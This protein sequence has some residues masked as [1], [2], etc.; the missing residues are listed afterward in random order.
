MTPPRGHP[1]HP[2]SILL[3]AAACIAACGAR[4][5][6]TTPTHD[7][8]AA[9]APTCASPT[10]QPFTQAIPS[11]A[12]RFEMRPIP[13]SA[14]GA[15]KPFFIATTELTWEAFDVFVYRL[16]E[17]GAIDAGASNI[18]TSSTPA[19]DA[20]TRPSKP[21]LPPDRGFGH[22]GFAAI[23]VSYQNAQAFCT[24]LSRTSGRV[25][26]LPTEA[27]WEHAC[28]AGATTPFS[29]GADPLAA[30]AHAWHAGNSGGTP[31]AVATRAPNAWGLFDMHGNVAEWVTGRDGKPV[32]KGGSYL[33]QPADLSATN[34]AKSDPAWNASDPQVPK[35]K[36]WLAD[37]PFVGFR[38]VCEDP[39][40]PAKQPA[41]ES[42]GGRP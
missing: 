40:A 30:D 26:R 10:P 27:E 35:S 11:A 23:T 6:P 17:G 1:L 3:P 42:L 34:R 36:W 14:D 28:L 2:L 38:V 29:F 19:P 31:H 9:P 13:A 22:E 41:A 20:V 4:P 8:S 32:T 25:Y 37:G 33:D 12:F 5:T 39:S 18:N 15:I 21:Y 7:A 16:D 24:W